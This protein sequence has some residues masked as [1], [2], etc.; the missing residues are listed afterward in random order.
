MVVDMA[1][2]V[3]AAESVNEVDGFSPQAAAAF[4]NKRDE[5][6]DETRLCS[7]L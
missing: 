4:S 6:L 7:M 3:E 5:D 1:E 2:I